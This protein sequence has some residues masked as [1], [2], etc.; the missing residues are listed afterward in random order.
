MLSYRAFGV[1]DWSAR[2][3]PTLAIHATLLIVYLI[4]RRSLGERGAFWGALLLGLSP[5][6]VS[7]GRLLLLDGL[8]TLWVT[9]TIMAAFEAVRGQSLRWSWW[10][11]SALACGLGILTNGPIRLILVVPP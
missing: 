1:H 8:L 3:V 7:M 9:L 11:L 5:G 4:G 10:F 2:L 6:F